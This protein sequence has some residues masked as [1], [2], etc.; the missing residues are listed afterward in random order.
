MNAADPSGPFTLAHMA[1]S[2][3][4]P[5]VAAA[6]RAIEQV[7]EET[8]A[9]REKG[10]RSPVTLADERAERILLAALAEIAPEI[11]VIAE[12][13]AER[14]GLAEAAPARFLL[15]DPL[16]GTKEFI[17]GGDDYTVN[18]ALVE[19]GRPVFGLVAAP[20]RGT[21]WIGAAGEGALAARLGAEGTLEESRRLAVRRA[22]ERI[23]I[24]ASRSHRNPKTERYLAH[25][26]D[27]ETVA[28]GSSLKF[29]L[30]AE[31]RAD[32]Y[33]RL[34]PTMEWDTAAGDAVL[35]AAGGR[36]LDERGRPLAYGK[37]GFRNGWFLAVGDP[38]LRPVPLSAATGAAE[39]D[40][41]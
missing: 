27:A 2:P 17:R 13:Q 34:G 40:R 41:A 28:I 25:Y 37:P 5:A 8:I 16:D 19:A 11:P 12:E 18:V 31:G 26:P 6:C 10:D 4:L 7:A 15:V 29:C 24:V 30:L 21:V 1:D 22:P 39:P 20:R 3:L 33:P 9:V 35:R 14:E 23:T 36:V 32:L 38:A